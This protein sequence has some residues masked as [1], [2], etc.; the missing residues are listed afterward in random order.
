MRSRSVLVALA[1]V[2]ALS[3]SMALA[4][5]GDLGHVGLTAGALTLDRQ[6]Q[7]DILPQARTEVA[8][9]L[10]GPFELGG[11]LQV[12]ALGFP[13]EMAS[14]GGA[15]FFQLRPDTNFFGFVPHA[16]IAGLR[17]TLPTSS[18]RY[19]AWGLSVGGGLGYE[20]GAGFVLE[21][22]VHH[23]WYFDLPEASGIGTDGWTFSGGFAY[24]LPS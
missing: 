16:E 22:R 10:W 9:R 20:V 2:A 11:Y 14:F 19:D 3:P 12:S 6:G 17:V 4:E 15:V 13:A 1:F 24:R 23:Q 7:T 8:F 5:G 18:E 21:L